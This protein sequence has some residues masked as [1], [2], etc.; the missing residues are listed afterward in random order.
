MRRRSLAER[1]LIRFDRLLQW[2]NSLD[3]LPLRIDDNIGPCFAFLLTDPIDDPDRYTEECVDAGHVPISYRMMRKLLF[4]L[5]E[6]NW[7]G[8]RLTDCHGPSG[9]T[10]ASQYTRWGER[11]ISIGRLSPLL[12]VEFVGTMVAKPRLVL[13]TS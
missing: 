9:Y 6:T 2:R 1:R 11:S 10:S 4:S 5:I 7:K 3:I 8:M 12:I 13:G